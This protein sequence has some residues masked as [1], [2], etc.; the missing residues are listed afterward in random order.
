MTHIAP[1]TQDY[2]RRQIV[3]RMGKVGTFKLGG[4]RY[5]IWKY[6]TFWA[7]HDQPS[8]CGEFVRQADIDKEGFLRIDNLKPGE[9]VVTPGL[10]YRKIPMSGMI[11]AEH[12]KKM[13]NFKPRDIVQHVKDTSEGAVDLGTIDLRTKH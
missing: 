12:M 10:I 1:S 4:K 2:Q 3:A 8:I 6:M 5:W 7:G 13:K 9:V 11:M